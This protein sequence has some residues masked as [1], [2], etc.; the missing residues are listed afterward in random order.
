VGQAFPTAEAVISISSGGAVLAAHQPMNRYD[1]ARQVVRETPCDWWWEYDPEDAIQFH[2]LPLHI[3]VLPT[4]A[5][6]VVGR[7]LGNDS[8]IPARTRPGLRC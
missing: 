1:L 8:S 5:R 7:T 4:T 3:D 2:A 6:T